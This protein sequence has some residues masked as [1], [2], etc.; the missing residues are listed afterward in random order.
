M[1]VFVLL[2]MDTC[3]F[4]NLPHTISGYFVLADDM[5]F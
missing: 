3:F 2:L 1:P 4:L 5:L